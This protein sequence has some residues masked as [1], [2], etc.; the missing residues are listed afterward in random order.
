MAAKLR[1]TAFFG[2]F[3]PEEECWWLA[4]E[5]WKASRRAYNK[6]IAKP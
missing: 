1:R 6:G 3:L 2:K 4:E 5:L